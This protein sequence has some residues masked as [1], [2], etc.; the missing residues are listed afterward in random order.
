MATLKN[1]NIDDTGYLQLPSGTTAQRPASPSAGY[2][3]WNTTDNIVEVYNGTYWTRMEIDEYVTDGLVAYLDPGNLDSYPGTGTTWSDLSGNSNDYTFGGN[4]TFDSDTKT[5]T[6][7]NTAGAG[8]GAL[9][10]STLTTSSTCTLV[11]WIKTTDDQALFWGSDPDDGYGGA[12]YVGAFRVG[13][14]EYY[15]N[16]GSPDYYQDLVQKSNIYD[17]LL[18]GEWHMVEFKNVDFSTW[19]NEHNFNSYSTYTFDNGDVGLILVYNKNLTESESLKNYNL[20]RDRFG[21]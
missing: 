2:M 15:G 13:N 8:G 6:L 4:L 9:N 5:F 14:K 7:S 16:C 12:F 21:I 19:T 3:R 11:F 18:D 20:F 1:T 10:D 17:N